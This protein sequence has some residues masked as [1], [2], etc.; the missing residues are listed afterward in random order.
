MKATAIYCVTSLIEMF[1]GN[2]KKALKATEFWNM[3]IEK[4]SYIKFLAAESCIWI[5]N[6]VFIIHLLHFHGIR[7]ECKLVPNSF[8]FQYS[9]Q[10][11]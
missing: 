1:F 6:A 2:T 4:V 8:K 7:R 11:I 3:N 5:N 9:R 10:L